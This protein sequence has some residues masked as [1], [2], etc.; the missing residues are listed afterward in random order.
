MAAAA[1]QSSK[2]QFDTLAASA[3]WVGTNGLRLFIQF[4]FAKTPMFW[5]PSGWVPGYVEWALSFPRAPKGSV[6]IQLWGIA[7]A[8]V[9]KM[10]SETVVAVYALVN[11]PKEGQQSAQAFRS[12]TD[13]AGGRP[14]TPGRK[15]L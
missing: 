11:A 6:S 5:V 2:A 4:W 3:R 12:G 1:I 8:S 14:G 15:E 10:I 9:I 13:T 7:C